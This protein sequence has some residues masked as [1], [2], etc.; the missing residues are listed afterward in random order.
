MTAISCLVRLVAPCPAGGQTG[1]LARMAGPEFTDA[2]SRPVVDE[3]SSCASCWISRNEGSSNQVLQ[4]IVGR[5]FDTW[6]RRARLT[7]K[8]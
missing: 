5:A 1:A 4:A 7:G 6:A 8:T 3:T 2:W